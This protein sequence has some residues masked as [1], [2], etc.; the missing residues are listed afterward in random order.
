MERKEL[1]SLNEAALQVQLNEAATALPDSP[2]VVQHYGGR[3][4]YDAMV[5]RLKK[6]GKKTKANSPSGGLTDAGA[7]W[8]ERGR[9]S[10][11]K[12]ES[13]EFALEYFENYF[14]DNLNED[15]SDEDI[16]EAVYDLIEL[17]EAVMDAVG[18][19]EAMDGYYFKG[20][21]EGDFKDETTK[22][23]PKST[24]DK[25]PDGEGVPTIKH[26]TAYL[27]NSRNKKIPDV[28]VPPKYRPK[29][30]APADSFLSSILPPRSN[31]P[32][33]TLKP[34]ADQLRTALA[35]QANRRRA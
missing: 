20:E 18:L 9:Q 26:D 23:H 35:K 8:M 13:V 25:G 15:T 10:K 6:K 22:R 21:K 7:E 30:D 29:V 2:G 14:G 3:E 4:K 31:K 12:V 32:I 11:S 5:K 16:M 34:S 28:V 19:D 27:P 1:N 33:R 17:T 24:V